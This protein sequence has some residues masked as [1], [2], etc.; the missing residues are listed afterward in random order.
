M[1]LACFAE[2]GKKEALIK[3]NG[4]LDAERAYEYI[5]FT[6]YD[7]F[8]SKLADTDPDAVMIAH[9]GA[10]GMQAVRAA[11]I[12]LHRVPTVWFSDDS[13][14]VEESYRLGCCFFSSEPLSEKI[15]TAA[16]KKICGEGR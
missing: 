13:G 6:S 15:F 9:S 7:D 10:L 2:C 8:I 14:F 11:K 4:R 3:L 5:F 12:L 16:L 1:I